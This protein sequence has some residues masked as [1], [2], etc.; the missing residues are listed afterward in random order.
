MQ[1]EVKECAALTPTH[2][3]SLECTLEGVEGKRW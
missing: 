2:T 3:D 1:A